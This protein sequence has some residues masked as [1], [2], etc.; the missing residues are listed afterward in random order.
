M[1]D[2]DPYEL[3]MSQVLVHFEDELKK[4][5]TGRSHPGMLDGIKVRNSITSQSGCQCNCA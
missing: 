1:F 5:R 4:V 2:T 3:K